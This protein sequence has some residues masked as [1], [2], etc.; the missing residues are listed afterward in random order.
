MEASAC[1]IGMLPGQVQTPK[2]EEPGEAQ[3]FVT[4]V[5]VEEPQ[6]DYNVTVGFDDD[7]MK[8]TNTMK[9]RQII[10]NALDMHESCKRVAQFFDE[11]IFDPERALAAWGKQGWGLQYDEDAE[12][13]DVNDWLCCQLL[14]EGKRS[15]VYAARLLALVICATVLPVVYVRNVLDDPCKVEEFDME[16]S[17]GMTQKVFLSRPTSS[18]PTCRLKEMFG[19][20]SSFSYVGFFFLPAACLALAAVYGVFLEIRDLLFRCGCLS[21]KIHLGL[22]YRTVYVYDS[23][24]QALLP[25]TWGAAERLILLLST[26]LIVVFVGIGIYTLYF[27]LAM[28]II[29]VVVPHFIAYANIFAAKSKIGRKHDVA[30]VISRLRCPT[31]EDKLIHDF[32]SL[33]SF[34]KVRD[35]REKVEQTMRRLLAHDPMDEEF[36]IDELSLLVIA[37]GL[38]E[39]AQMPLRLRRFRVLLRDGVT[40]KIVEVLH[41]HSAISL[42]VVK[43]PCEAAK[44]SYNWDGERFCNANKWMVKRVH[45]QRWQLEP[46]CAADDPIVFKVQEKASRLPY[47]TSPSTLLSG[48]WS[49]DDERVELKTN[50]RIDAD[51]LNT[52]SLWGLAFPA[53]DDFNDMLFEVLKY[54][55]DANAK[56]A[57]SVFLAHFDRKDVIRGALWEG[58]KDADEEVR[59]LAAAELWRLHEPAERLLP[60]L[61]DSLQEHAPKVRLAAMR[62]VA[63]AVGDDCDAVAAQAL[64]ALTAMDPRQ[65][66]LLLQSSDFS[67]RCGAVRAL[68]AIQPAIPAPPAE[69]ASVLLGGQLGEYGM[70]AMTLVSIERPDAAAM[71]LATAMRDSSA[72]V[73]T[74]AAAALGALG[75]VDQSAVRELRAIAQGEYHDEEVVKLDAENAVLQIDRRHVGT[76]PAAPEHGPR[77]GAAWPPSAARESQ[78]GPLEEEAAV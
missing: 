30:S 10:K 60:T 76:A 27:P 17:A 7:H 42:E 66:A 69:A 26:G 3:S 52:A 18:N 15:K 31:P 51:N 24:S 75:E 57:K 55:D 25:D 54:D 37:A 50:N 21:P 33:D 14:N 22:R 56:Q 2:D 43:A 8:R 53:H 1:G 68:A 32:I 34:G 19:N 62:S 39:K 13:P 6:P 78:L 46:M 41:K 35:L 65:L 28:L 9:R 70:A 12:E 73:R 36:E 45:Q 77:R 71:A 63:V 48:E 5:L 74:E 47:R 58:L 49:C 16:D 4:E 64:E 59:V 67:V 38:D 20:T 61:I 40:E 23:V 11:Y 44:G 72:G 29:F